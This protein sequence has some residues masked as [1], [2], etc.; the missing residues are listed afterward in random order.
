MDELMDVERCGHTLDIHSA[1]RVIR[2]YLSAAPS[3]PPHPVVII[4]IL[5]APCMLNL[6]LKPLKVVPPSIRCSVC[7]CACASVV[8][9]PCQERGEGSD[10]GGREETTSAIVA[11]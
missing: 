1:R 6:I 5:L 3:H 9:L 7:S 8:I 11:F 2:Q 10:R 4:F